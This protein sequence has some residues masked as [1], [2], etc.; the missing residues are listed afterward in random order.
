MSQND[1]PGRK[2]DLFVKAWVFM[3]AATSP[4]GIYAGLAALAMFLIAIVAIKLFGH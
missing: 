4:L 3:F 1:L 2:P